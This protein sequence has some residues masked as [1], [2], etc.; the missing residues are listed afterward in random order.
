MEEETVVA[1]GLPDTSFSAG[2]DAD[3]SVETGTLQ[4]D[5][6]VASAALVIAALLVGIVIRKGM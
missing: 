6:N 5:V 4:W 1:L 2:V 3:F